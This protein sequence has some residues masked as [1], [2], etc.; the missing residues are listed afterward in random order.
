MKQTL[1]HEYVQRHCL[2]VPLVLHTTKTNVILWRKNSTNDDVIWRLFSVCWR[3]QDY[4]PGFYEVNYLEAIHNGFEIKKCFRDILRSEVWN[5][6]QY[7][8]NI[9]KTV[10]D[11]KKEKF[12]A[13]KN[14]EQNLAAWEMFLYLT[15]SC[16]A[17]NFSYEAIKLLE[18]SIRSGYSLKKR[19]FAFYKAENYL[20]QFN[21]ISYFWFQ[22]IKPISAT[23]NNRWLINL[24]NE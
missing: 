16:L 9:L 21:D 7:E 1:C 2:D 6:D 13:K 22:R 17:K 24:I 8:R 20:K 11:I 18:E 3:A 19:N 4:H 23:Y 15:D 5:W 14:T 12:L 10:E